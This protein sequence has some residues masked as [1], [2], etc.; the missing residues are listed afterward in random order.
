MNATEIK[1]HAQGLLDDTISLFRKELE[2]ARA[3]LSQKVSQAQSGIISMM[4]GALIAFV[5]VIFLGHS[6]MALLDNYVAPEGAALIV[7]LVFLVIGGFL[8]MSARESLS[9]KA[10]KPHRTIQSVEEMA[11]HARNA[12]SGPRDEFKRETTTGKV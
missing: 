8:L 9:G 3:E 10:L 6:A 7:A 12:T 2:L 4:A 11:A 1:M 5:G